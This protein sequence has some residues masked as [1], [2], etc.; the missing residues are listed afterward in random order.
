MTSSGRKD[1]GG[2]RPP[3]HLTLTALLLP[4]V[5]AC[6]GAP[7]AG[8]SPAPDTVP[9]HWLPPIY[10]A[11]YDTAEVGGEITA[12]QGRLIARCMREAGFTYP[13]LDPAEI[14]AP[15]RPR[16]FGLESLE[17]PLAAGESPIAEQ[18]GRVD[19]RYVR[20]LY[21]D[22]DGCQTQADVRLLGERQSL[23]SWSE[24]RVGLYKA[25]VEAKNLLWRHPD[26]A[27]LNARWATC[28]KRAGFTFRDPS[29]VLDGLPPKATFRAEPSARADV[30]C[31]DSTG[32]LRSAYTGLA[33]AQRHALAG[34]P[35]LLP[36]WK[37]LLRR[38]CETAR[39]ILARPAAEAS[40][41]CPAA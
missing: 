18:P 31:K 34:S 2:H 15:D 26:F 35:D 20:A 5:V 41:P 4:V 3:R 19:Q 40:S 28:M 27:E 30:A 10:A 9:P 36:T 7:A 22:E 32:Y 29:Q 17:Q 12:A 37:A 13:D 38:Q 6:S 24:T 11:V 1:L 16:P 23:R 8:P 25:E 39:Q 21:D 33:R 14:G